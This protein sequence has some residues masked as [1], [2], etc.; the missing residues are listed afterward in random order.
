MFGAKKITKVHP[1]DST[2]GVKP[3]LISVAI[4]LGASSAFMS[5]F[6]YQTNLMV[7]GAGNYTTMEFVKYGA[8]LK[9]KYLV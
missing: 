1:L 3:Q 4:M 9:V 7:Y 5:P 2:T 8:G 6:G